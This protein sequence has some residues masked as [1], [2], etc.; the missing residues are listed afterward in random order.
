MMLIADDDDLYLS[1][2]LRAIRSNE[3]IDHIRL[4]SA[5][6]GPEAVRMIE[7]KKYDIILTDLHMPEVPGDL[8]AEAA[9]EENPEIFILIM[10][11]Y[12]DLKSA[13]DLIKKGIY[14][15]IPKP[16][17]TSEL[18]LKIRRIILQI[19]QK[20]ELEDLKNELNRRN[21]YDSSIVYSDPKMG[22]LLKTASGI[23]D[24]DFP[25]LIMG[26]SGTGKELIADLIHKYSPR[27][28][29]PFIKINCAGL[30]SSLLE[31]ELFGHE[32]GAFTGALRE[33]PGKF[34][35]ADH[36]TLFLDEI[37]DME[38]SIQAKFLRLL[39][40]GEFQ[41][42][43]GTRTL[44]SDVRI[45]AAT[46]KN[47]KKQIEAG[48]F[49][50]DLYYRLNTIEIDIPPLRERTSDIP[51]LVMH[52]LDALG[53]HYNRPSAG[54]S[55]EAIKV[56]SAY[57]YPG[58]IRELENIISH[59]YALARE[60]EITI[61]DLPPQISRSMPKGS[62][63]SAETPENDIVRIHDNLLRPLDIQVSELEKQA[64]TEALKQTGNNRIQ[65]AKILNIS[66][67]QFYYKLEKYD[68]S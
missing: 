59:A 38:M 21:Q 25:V 41:R 43:G 47:L 62:E 55:K 42:V 17:N 35:L 15:Y 7:Q 56:L 3:I 26:E 63:S 61:E 37:G 58:N 57:S 33:K 5:A 44:K 50:E 24:T 4:D 46:N 65:A 23:A 8:V 1:S 52:F 45:L 53:E 20:N 22:K 18:I 13:V 19:K 36:G 2:L 68:I 40:Q 16:F 10:T 49:R 12:S 30:V 29:G 32:K 9:L 67:R 27:S 66:R 48:E 31:S 6:G 60:D 11:G 64:I 39:Q 28:N 54:V 14:D 34:E 51:L